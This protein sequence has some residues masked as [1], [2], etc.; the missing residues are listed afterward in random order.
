MSGIVSGPIQ[1][2]LVPPDHW[3]Q[4]EW[5]DEDRAAEGRHKLVSANVIYGGNDQSYYALSALKIDCFHR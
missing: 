2:G 4:P 1:F 5:I 3:N